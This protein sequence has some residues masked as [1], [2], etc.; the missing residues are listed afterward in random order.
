MESIPLLWNAI[1]WSDSPRS[2]EFLIFKVSGGRR[3]VGKRRR[4][5]AFFQTFDANQKQGSHNGRTSTAANVSHVLKWHWTW[6]RTY[7]K[8]WR[9]P[10]TRGEG[11]GRGIP[12]PVHFSLSSN[13]IVSRCLNHWR[14]GHCYPTA[15]SQKKQEQI[16]FSILK[17]EVLFFFF[18]V[19]TQNN[20]VSLF[21]VKVVA[22]CTKDKIPS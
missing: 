5:F 8:N 4:R 19:S 20:F 9:L 18:F 16:P 13:Y 6:R 15:D 12:L 22:L 21:V 2:D 7:Q 14:K 11:G 17:Q 3:T 1:K 10:F